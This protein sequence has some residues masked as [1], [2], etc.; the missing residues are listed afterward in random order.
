MEV[1][2][3]FIRVSNIKKAVEW[4]KNF[5][6]VNIKWEKPNIIA[7]QLKNAEL[8]IIEKDMHVVDDISFNFE[9]DD[10]TEFLKKMEEK[11][12]EVSDIKEWEEIK[13]VT[14]YDCDKNE[15]QVVEKLS[16]GNL[17]GKY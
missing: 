17:C 12:I 10:L 14:L 3:I 6:E 9:V 4:Y 11:R 16:H 2:T 15:I 13:Y 1:K 8:T 5:L 7:F